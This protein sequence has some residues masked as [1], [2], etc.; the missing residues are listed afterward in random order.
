M[1]RQS[2]ARIRRRRI[3]RTRQQLPRDQFALRRRIEAAGGRAR[4]LDRECK[5]PRA[6][7]KSTATASRAASRLIRATSLSS[8]VEAHQ[9]MHDSNFGERCLDG[10]QCARFRR[11]R[12]R[13]FR[14]ACPAAVERGGL[15]SSI[16]ASS[17]RS[18]RFSYSASRRRTPSVT[19]RH[20][21]VAPEMLWMSES[22]RTGSRAV[23]PTNC[24]R[25]AGRRISLPCVSRYSSTSTPTHRAVHIE[26]ER[27]GD[28]L[29]L[30]DDLIDDEP[31]VRRTVL[32]RLPDLVAT[33][34]CRAHFPERR[35]QRH[36][37]RRDRARP[38]RTRSLRRT[39]RAAIRRRSCTAPRTPRDRPAARR[40]HRAR[41]I[42]RVVS[43]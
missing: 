38:A 2:A 16:S 36:R 22:S 31:T 39:Q 21:S 15:A 4:E 24:L 6:C 42:S 28:R 17:I 34:R 26:R 19:W 12:R 30:A 23:L 9:P 20:D 27:V 5:R 43:S 8:R 37:A 14:R 11:R 32:A 33:S 29:G 18:Q 10:G 41:A 3:G 13:V 1:S 7:A 35:Q 40:A 25:Q